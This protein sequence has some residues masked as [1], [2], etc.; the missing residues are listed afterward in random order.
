MSI[1]KRLQRIWENIYSQNWSN[2]IIELLI[3]IL[4]IFIAFQFAMWGERI[5]EKRQYLELVTSV[6]LENE[7]NLEELEEL[8]TYRHQTV[9]K[10]KSLLGILNAPETASKDSIRYF[11]FTLNRISTP[12]LQQQAL[13]NLIASTFS[14]AN[15][16]LK[17]EAI[18]LK[19]LYDEWLLSSETFSSEKSEKFFEFLYDDID[20]LNGEILNYDRIFSLRF[21]NQVLEICG[22]EIEQTRL[23]E[24]VVK[25]FDLFHKQ[26]LKELE[27]T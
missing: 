19:A 11:I 9:E 26:I 23:Y 12:D 20:F 5:Q 17:N 10:S 25:Q 3:V 8:K 15:M 2:H 21:K 24:M 14:V 16:G 27:K 7:K 22:S 4:G 13:E 6:K 18:R 1:K